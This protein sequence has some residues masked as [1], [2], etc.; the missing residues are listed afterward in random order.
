MVQMTLFPRCARC[1]ASKP[2]LCFATC[3]KKGRQ[4]WC[5]DCANAYSQKRFHKDPARSRRL[6]IDWHKRNPE[7]QAEYSRKN[8]A[9][10]KAAQLDRTPAWADLDAMAV[11]YELCP[12]GYHVDHIVPLQGRLVSGLHVPKNLQYLTASQNTSKR[13]RYTPTTELFAR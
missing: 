4:R 12:P 10:R 1:G 7:K 2:L 11:I 5:R 9:K 13:H 3:K 8:S 6:V